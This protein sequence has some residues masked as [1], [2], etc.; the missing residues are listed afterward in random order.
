MSQRDTAWGPMQ[1]QRVAATEAAQALQAAGI[2]L[3]LC[4]PTLPWIAPE[5]EAKELVRRAKEEGAEPV[6]RGDAYLLLA[7]AQQVTSA[8]LHCREHL[9]YAQLYDLTAC[10]PAVADPQLKLIYGLRNLKSK[11]RLV[12]QTRVDKAAASLPSVVSVYQAADW[13]E[14]EAGEMY[15]ITFDGHPDPRNILLP[16]DWVGFPLRKDYVYPDEYNGVSC[17]E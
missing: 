16:D 3:E 5:G 13:H 17:K 4:V 2:E 9:G 6:W 12:I 7:D 1:V 14:R 15:G 8:L 10:D 11:A